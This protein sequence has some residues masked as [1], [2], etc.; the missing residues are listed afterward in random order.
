MEQAPLDP[1]RQLKPAPLEPLGP[2]DAGLEAVA[3]EEAERAREEGS[4]ADT[5][6]RRGGGGLEACVRA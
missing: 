3:G 1:K 6:R 4:E 5:V 2:P